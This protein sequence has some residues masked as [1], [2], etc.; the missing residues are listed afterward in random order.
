MLVD[1]TWDA[2]QVA[3]VF[4]EGKQLLIGW[5]NQLNAPVYTE[6]NITSPGKGSS[7]VPEGMNGGAFA[8]VTTQRYDTVHELGFGMSAGPVLVLLS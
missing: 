2:T 5:V 8:V 3:F 7:L 6:L 1:F 4:E